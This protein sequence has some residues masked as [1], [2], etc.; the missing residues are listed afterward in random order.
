MLAPQHLKPRSTINPKGFYLIFSSN[1]YLDVV[2]ISLEPKGIIG[3]I[4]VP[5]K[6][7]SLVQARQLITKTIDNIPTEFQFLYG[8]S[9]LPI[10]HAQEAF[11]TVGDHYPCI[12]LREVSPPKKQQRKPYQVVVF[13]AN[14][15]AS[16]M[17]WIPID[18]TFGQL[19]KD[20]ARYFDILAS[21]ANLV[22]KDGCTW[23]EEAAIVP[24]LFEPVNEALVAKQLILIDKRLPKP[25]IAKENPIQPIKN[26]DEK[27]W[28]I[29]T[30]YCVHGDALD[31]LSMTQYQFNRFLRDCGLFSRGF[32][33]AMGDII[34]AFEGK[35]KL[36]K[37]Q[38]SRRAS[39]KLDYDGFLNALYTIATRRTSK[40]TEEEAMHLLLS[41]Y[42]LPNALTWPIG[43]WR[44]HSEQLAQPEVRA[45]RMKFESMLYD[46]FVFYTN[47]PISETES[48]SRMSFNDYMRFIND[49]HFTELLLSTQECPEIFLAACQCVTTTNRETMDFEAFQDMLGRCGVVGLTRHRN[50]KPLQC[51]KAVF[52]HMTRGLKSSRALEIIHNHGPNA[53]YAARFYQGCVAFSHKF[54]DVWRMEGSPD[55][56]T[57]CLPIVTN[58]L[59]RGRQVLHQILRVE[60]APVAPLPK[61][62]HQLAPASPQEPS[63]KRSIVNQS[64][65]PTKGE[66]S[67]KKPKEIWQLPPPPTKS[68]KKSSTLGPTCTFAR[69]LSCPGLTYGNDHMITLLQGSVLRKYGTWGQPQRRYVWCSEDGDHLLWR[70]LKSKKADE[71]LLMRSIVAVL[72]GNTETTKYAFMKYLSEEKN[73]RRCFSI[74]TKERRLN[75]E[76]DSDSICDRWI[77]ALTYLIHD[78]QTSR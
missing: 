64:Q 56:I 73:L 42:I 8:N 16:F 2:R 38:A 23:P 54:L 72:P 32:T 49:F 36:S 61:K 75:F 65:Q 71:C 33:P 41:Q 22:D 55:Y 37:L 7:L 52:H 78:R 31:L 28:Y 18:Y 4:D 30:S 1:A 69:S 11:L 53:M 21:D 60:G 20:A 76:A 47:Q 74:M 25:V 17:S 68:L 46:I 13:N 19:R 59:T 43:T 15:K 12:Q 62:T 35:G 57:G 39:G 63:Q 34:Y 27:L 51:V 24:T 6:N 66:R 70:S 50:L 48:E 67:S 14:T 58:Q 9:L 5:D 10:S 29:F 26:F 44:H 3:F 45:F 40:Q 77:Q